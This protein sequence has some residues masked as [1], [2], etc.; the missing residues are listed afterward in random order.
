MDGEPP[1]V[2]ERRRLQEELSE[3]VESCCR[4]LEEVTTSLGWSLDR[5]DPGKEEAA[6]D[7]V[8]ICPYDSNH[9]MPKSSLAKHMVS[10]RLRKLGYTREEE[11]E[12][13]NSEFFY[14]NV[15]IPSITLNK[16]SQFQ[17]IKQARTTVGKDGDSY[18]QR[19]YSTLPVEVPLNHK[20]FVCDLTQADRLALY[21][22]VIEETKKQRS[23]SQI[24]ENDSDLFVDLAAK[25]NQDNSRKSPKSY[26]EILAEVRDYKRRRQ[27]YRA[28]NVHI[29]K[30]SYTEVIRDVINV[31]ME[32]LSNHWQEEQER[33][34]DDAEKNEERR[35]AS[36]DSR[37]SGGS[38][39]DAECS[40]HRR[41]RSRSPHKRRRNKDKDKNWD[42]RRRKER[43]G[44]RHH[45]HKRR[46]QK[47]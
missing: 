4:R 11:D 46:K 28:K 14:E 25:V 41:D 9:H 42:S 21:D 29:T 32:E 19:I 5:L 16:D 24:I 6:E 7:E 13:Y 18:N 12:M 20:R 1:P 35:S 34:E 36:V 10:C 38:Y 8:V 37:Q 17:I 31:H 15:K 43:D 27:S 23:D 47:V 33:A 40:R 44:E 30:K 39:L 2:E 26:L 45:S 22:F 3:F